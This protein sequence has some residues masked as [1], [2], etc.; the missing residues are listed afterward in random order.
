MKLTVVVTD[1]VV[2]LGLQTHHGT[3]V[4]YVGESG[5]GWPWEGAQAAID[6][7]LVSKIDDSSD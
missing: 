1:L 7:Y 6:S 3:G 2:H 4:P 5:G